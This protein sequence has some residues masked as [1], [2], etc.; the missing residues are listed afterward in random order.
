MK[1]VELLA[2][3]GDAACF[4][5]AVAA[6][7][8]A[9]YC[10]L[11]RFSARTRAHNL[12]VKE[13]QKLIPLARKADVKV[14]L[15]VNTLLLDNEIQ[16][17]LN[18]IKDAVCAGVDALIIQ[19]LGLLYAVRQN[20]AGLVDI[21]AS[22]QMTTHNTMQCEFL[23]L[24]GVTQV[25]LSRELDLAQIKQLADN[26]ANHGIKTEVFIHGAFCLSFSGQCYMSGI[27][28][29][30]HGNRGSCI[31][32]C[33]R[34]YSTDGGVAFQPFNLKDN[35]AFA[36]AAELMQAGADSLKIEGRIKD[37]EYVWTVTKAW[38]EQLDRLKSGNPPQN[39]SPVLE[40]IV[41]RQYTAGY[42][43]GRIG[44]QM[45]SEGSKDF[46]QKENGTVASYHA[47]RAELCVK[48]GSL[49]PQDSVTIKTKNGDFVCTAV[50]TDVARKQDGISD[51]KILITGKLASKI[52]KGQVVYS[53]TPVITEAQLKKECEKLEPAKIPLSIAV[54]GKLGQNLKALF[55]TADGKTVEVQ[56]ES[57][58]SAAV[59]KGLDEDL[60]REKLGKLGGT[61]FIAES[62]SFACGKGEKLF[63]PVSQLN[64]MRQK[65]VSELL[66]GGRAQKLAELQVNVPEFDGT[67]KPV[68]K[69]E[70]A[71]I[72]DSVQFAAE[73]AGQGR[74]VVLQLSLAWQKIPASFFA[75][76]PSI[77]PLFP[78]ILFEE[79]LSQAKK[80]V[81]V[82]VAQNA[83]P[84]IWCEN[85]GLALFAFR[86]GAHLI[87][88]SRLN[89]TNS[90]SLH[91]YNEL[92]NAD[93]VIPSAE[94]APEYVANLSVPKNCELWYP[95]YT[96]QILMESRQ[97]LLR[98][99]TGCKKTQ[100][101]ADCRLCRK[102][103]VLTG[104]QN[105]RVRAVNRPGAY[106]A[107]Q[108]EHILSNSGLVPTLKD[109]VS[110]WT[111]DLTNSAGEYDKSQLSHAATNAE[112]FLQKLLSGDTDKELFPAVTRNT[113]FIGNNK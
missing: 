58:L 28:Y 13:L 84:R 7:A 5:T 19:D 50:V 41:N 70:I 16:D 3:A 22:T 109:V 112:S 68:K 31:Q 52:E 10:G 48:N 17:A 45:F 105:E 93:A 30:E 66:Q 106:S 76:N 39:E 80:L 69:P 26:L 14:Y 9:I 110:T 53:R 23:S 56:S 1:S 37:S 95:L 2:P 51:C 40:R 34:A 104:T 67:K 57:V 102:N 75:K 73:L 65:A 12:T 36:H 27:L 38:R 79:D 97:C 99:A 6:G 78:A 81:E 98:R 88:G 11:E 29:G 35:N 42:L 4:K 60:L 64:E 62:V 87:L 77:I 101:D 85:T 47:D 72:T 108:T 96:H 55:T 44:A 20:F 90:C 107:L 18:L 82:I 32:P 83:E 74:T 61:G 54:S 89:I 15:T 111:V 63:V 86:H 46:S 71:F 49:L 59:S 43:E 94:L 8:N 24:C 21:H 25:N 100:F 103:V 91:Y 92:L 113:N 33:R